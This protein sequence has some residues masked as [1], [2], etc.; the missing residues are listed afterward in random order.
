VSPL[1]RPEIER[2]EDPPLR[3]RQGS[4][5]AGGLA[6]PGNLSLPGTT[7][8]SVGPCTLWVMALSRSGQTWSPATPFTAAARFEKRGK[9][10]FDHQTN[11]ESENKTTDNGIHDSTK[12][13][14]RSTGTNNPEGIAFTE[15]LAAVN[16]GLL[17]ARTRSW[18]DC[19]Q[20]DGC[21]FAGHMKWQLATLGELKTIVD[22]SNRFPCLD[23]TFGPTQPDASWPSSSYA[24]YPGS[25]WCV[26]FNFGIG[27]AIDNTCSYCVRVVRGSP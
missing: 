16:R 26:Y 25:A 17:R 9:T 8:L 21:G 3:L 19:E 1:A 12:F 10:V 14:A 2:S 18:A 5:Q 15:F 6:A 24:Y 20:Q 22:C 11:L 13:D 27:N 23:P 4:G 7:P